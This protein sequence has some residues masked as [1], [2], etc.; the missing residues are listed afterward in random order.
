MSL[1]IDIS[2]EA[3]LSAAAR[4]L[5]DFAGEARIF[6]FEAPMGAGKT[7]FIRQLCI[8]LGSKDHFSS[9]TY[10]IV[11]EYASPSGKLFHFDLYRLRSEEELYDIG[12]EE[13]LDG[14]HYCFIEWPQIAADL[15]EDP[16]LI[17]KISVEEGKRLLTAELK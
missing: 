11:N 17:V 13:Y 7:T 14:R 9:P 15:L 12:F 1:K 3:S 4:Q 5:L 8:A 16:F 10:S 2:D 6:A